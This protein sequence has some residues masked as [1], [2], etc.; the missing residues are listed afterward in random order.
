[1]VAP[2]FRLQVIYGNDDNLNFCGWASAIWD[3]RP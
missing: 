3:A 1:M 2:I